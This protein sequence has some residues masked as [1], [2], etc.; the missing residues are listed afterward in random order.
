MQ[1]LN[2][3]SSYMCITLCPLTLKIYHSL[4]YMYNIILKWIYYKLTLP[5]NKLKPDLKSDSITLIDV[6]NIHHLS[7]YLLSMSFFIYLNYF[8][9]I[10][11]IWQSLL[12]LNVC[13]VHL[14]KNNKSVALLS[15]HK[16]YKNIFH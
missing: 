2:H 12:F 3:I 8:I 4:I 9:F 5:K 14:N 16:K 13:R 15:L 10:C 6:I 7:M 1:I 11:S